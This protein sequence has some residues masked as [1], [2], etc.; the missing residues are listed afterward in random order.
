MKFGYKCTEA[1]R[2]LDT[3]P[4]PLPSNTAQDTTTKFTALLSSTLLNAALAASKLGGS[5]N[6]SKTIQWTSRVL[7][8]DG[9]SDAEK[10]MS[11]KFP[12]ISGAVP[13]SQF[14]FGSTQPRHSTV[15][16][17]LSSHNQILTK[18]SRISSPHVDW[19]PVM[20]TSLRNWRE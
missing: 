7:R 16:R 19:F 17:S 20:R 2:Y 18:P 10:G 6:S 11:E 4:L 14:C 8:L 5:S 12:L 15:V 1:V 3:H 13:D 9:L